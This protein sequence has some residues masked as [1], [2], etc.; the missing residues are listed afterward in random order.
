MPKEELVTVSGKQYL[1]IGDKLAEVDHFDANGKP[2]L[3]TWSESKENAAGGIDCT[4]HVACLQI[5]ASKPKVK[6]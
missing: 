6:E 5:A 4:V 2:V 1:R 3:K